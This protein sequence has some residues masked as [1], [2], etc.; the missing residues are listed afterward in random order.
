MAEMSTKSKKMTEKNK[1]VRDDWRKQGQEN[2]LNGVNL[3]FKLYSP[4]S[5]EWDHDHCEFCW[6]KFS[7]NEGDLKRGYTNEDGY[8]WICLD[9]F[10]DFKDEFAWK[11]EEL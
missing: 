2:Y 8:R 3:F 4:C 10:N 5:T 6:N 9:C 1:P 11:V 7:L